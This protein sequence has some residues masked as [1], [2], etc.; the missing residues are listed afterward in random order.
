MRRPAFA[1]LAIVL[2]PGAQARD[3]MSWL[4][5]DIPPASMPV[6]GKP[7]NG[8]ADQIVLY[9]SAR[10]PEVEHRFVYANPKRSW[11]MIERGERACVVAA[12]RNAAREKLAYF[13]DTS[14]VPPPQLVVQPG[15]LSRLPLNAHGEADMEKLI[16]DPALRG[17][18]VER[19]SYGAAVDELIAGRPAGSRLETTSV[20]DYGRNVLKLVAHGRADYTLDYDY[21]LQ[22]AS[23]RDPSIGT[24][25]TVPIAQNNKPLLGG[26]ACPRNAW[27]QAA[28]RR[29]D[30][31]VGTPEGAAAMLKAQDDWHTPASRRRY[32][33]ELSEFQRQRSHPGK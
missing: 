33:S 2:A 13:V 27:G 3:T 15:T 29:I 14:L 9:I 7:S 32:A 28:V 30:R 20:G 17:I 31:I 10:W 11:L 24:L 8:F 12:L 19:R 5:P 26:I 18:V 23:S 21:A 4:M 22:Y 1:L 25:A 16:A 6:N